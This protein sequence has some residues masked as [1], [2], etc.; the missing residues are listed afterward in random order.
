MSP[1]GQR[2]AGVVGDLVDAPF[3]D[4]EE[5]AEAAWLLA[6]DAD[7]AAPAPSESIAKDYEHLEDMLGDLPAGPLDDR[8]Q[9]EVLKAA[10]SRVSPAQRR[11]RPIH[12]WVTGGAIAAAAAFAVILLRPG[13]PELEVAIRHGN[14]VVRGHD[15]VVV[16]DHLV[17]EAHVKNGAGDLRVFEANGMPVAQCPGGPGCRH[18]S[19]DHYAIDFALEKLVPYQVILVV[20]DAA[21]VAGL[22]DGTMQAFLRAASASDVRVVTYGPIDVN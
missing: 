15:K 10:A 16:G 22:P 4:E 6:R 8:W 2:T 12:A 19:H 11:W 14:E 7:P 5:R 18:A 20:G 21:V 9:D 17:V 13:L 1:R 3:I